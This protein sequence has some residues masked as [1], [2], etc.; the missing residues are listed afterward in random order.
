MGISGTSLESS[1]FAWEEKVLCIFFS[2]APD[3]FY[4]GVSSNYT[5]TK[6]NFFWLIQI[7]LYKLLFINYKQE[8]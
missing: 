3:L 4:V 7:L 6:N 5:T 8:L 2:C 1:S